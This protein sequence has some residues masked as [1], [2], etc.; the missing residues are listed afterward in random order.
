MRK[1]LLFTAL[2]FSLTLAS[3]GAK[4]YVECKNPAKINGK[5]YCEQ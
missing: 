1:I 2:I 5:V 4:K 3:C